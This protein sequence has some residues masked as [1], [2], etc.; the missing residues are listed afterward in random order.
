MSFT[1]FIADL[2]LQESEPERTK[3]FL[4]FLQTV[5]LQ[6]EALYILG[7]L[8]EAWIGDD[9]NA[10]FN[11]TIRSAF[12]QFTSS[13]IPIYLM[14]GNRDFLLGKK[15]AENS[16]CV[17]ITEDP[18]K[19]YL[20]GKT[21]LLTHG[22]VLC[23]ND[24]LLMWFR[25]Y[26]HNPKLYKY[27]LLLPIVVRKFLA[28]MI[29]AKSKRSDKTKGIDVAT[30]VNFMQ[31]YRTKQLIHGHVHQATL[32][33]IKVPNIGKCRYITLGAWDEAP[34]YLMY[35]EDHNVKMV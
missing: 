26:A 4:H 6:A 10:E 22:D 11:A 35:Y 19:I 18:T 8:F 17:L 14:H 34:S 30:I 1:L 33:K 32:S 31:Q 15:F 9:V 27:F 25:K 24:R 12:K 29:R 28:Q 16:G 21:T 7:D 5:A 20:Y 3:M 23:I 13:G 2:H